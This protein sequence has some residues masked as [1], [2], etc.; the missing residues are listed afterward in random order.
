MHSATRSL[1]AWAVLG[2]VFSPCTA[3]A[4]G[5]ATVKFNLPS[6]SLAESLR[7]VASQ[8][9]TN[10]LF[11]RALVRG[12]TAQALDAQLNLDQAMRRLLAGTGLT[13]LKT[14]EKTVVIAVAEKTGDPA[15]THE[16]A[17]PI[18]PAPTQHFA[19]AA[20]LT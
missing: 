11:D 19:S 4:D 10:I 16:T 12:L 13:Y 9:Q 20:G 18:S 3:H 5:Q 1:F 7:A 6:Q 17:S 15:T 8:T 14:D 2:W